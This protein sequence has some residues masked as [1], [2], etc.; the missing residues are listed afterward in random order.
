MSKVDTKLALKIGRTKSLLESG[1]SDQEIMDALGISEATL[2][3]YKDTIDR[4]QQNSK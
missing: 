4:A 1:Y 2:R 3:K